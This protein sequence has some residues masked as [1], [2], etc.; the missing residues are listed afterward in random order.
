MNPWMDLAKGGL[1]RIVIFI[2]H[3]VT[4]KREEFNLPTLMA[5]WITRKLPPKLSAMNSD[6]WRRVDLP[7]HLMTVVQSL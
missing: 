7:Q 4:A 5:S 2:I 6:K 3:Y 1:V